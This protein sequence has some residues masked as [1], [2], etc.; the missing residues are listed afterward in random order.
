MTCSPPTL[1]ELFLS[2]YGDRVDAS[3]R[4]AEMVYAK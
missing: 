2:H 4:A 3:P 1:E